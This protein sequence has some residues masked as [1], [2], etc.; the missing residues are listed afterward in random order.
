MEDRFFTPSC[1]FGAKTFKVID[2][3]LYNYRQRKTGSNHSMPSPNLYDSVKLLME[4]QKQMLLD[5]G[6]FEK[7][8]SKYEIAC[9]NYLSLYV[10]RNLLIK[11][12]FKTKMLYSK[13][14]VNDLE[15]KIYVKKHKKELKYKKGF[16][17]KVSYF[18]RSP[19]LLAFF[20]L[21]N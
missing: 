21:F 16:A 20:S 19:F 13:Y 5:K 1:M 4:T 10:Q 18:F 11:T 7:Y 15:L 12:D 3:R 6:L 14:V 17:I 8:Q 9:L 2:N